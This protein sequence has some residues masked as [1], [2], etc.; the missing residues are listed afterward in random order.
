MRLRAQGRLPF[1]G[2][3]DFELQAEALDIRWIAHLLQLDEALEGVVDLEFSVV[4]TDAE[5]VMDL[6]LSADGFR[7]RD[8]VMERLGANVAYAARRATGDVVLWNDS[9]QVL[10]LDGELPLD[11]SFNAVEDRFPEEVIDLVVVS[12]RFPLSLLMAPFPDYEDVVGTISG[13]VDIGGTSR[14]LAPQGRMSVEGGGVFLGGLGVRYEDVSGTLG[15]FPDGRVEVDMSAQALGTASVEGT[16]MLTTVLDPGLA[17]DFRFDDFQA[18]DRRD[19]TGRLSGAVRLEGSLSRPVV[20]G[21]LFVDEGTLFWEEFQRLAGVSDLLF[22]RSIGLED[23]SVADTTAAVSRSFIGGQ[24]LF[25]QNIRMENTTLTVRRNTWIRGEEMNVQLSG[26]VDL[27]YDRQSQDLALVGTLEAVRGS[28][29][30]GRRALRKQVQVDGGTLRFLGT[31]GINPD[32]DITGRE[33]IRTP[34]G[35]RLTIIASVTGTLLAP[36]VELSSD[37]VGFSEEELLSYLWFGR[38]TYALTS[39][40]NEAVGAGMAIGLNTLSSELGAVMAQGLDFLD[41]L[42]I[43]QQDLG[44]LGSLTANNVQALGTTVVETGFYVA[45]DMFLTLLFRSAAA[46]GGIESW[47]GIRFEW[48]AARGYTLQSYFEDQFFRGRAVGFGELGVQTRKGLGL[49]LF[50]NWSY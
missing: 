22:E 10:S 23:L 15:W 44:S 40:Q 12:D 41:Y 35:D 37:E 18:M 36:R 20:S 2:E 48:T 24:S 30:L 14:I 49:S 6:A 47:P 27:L 29:G 21:D 11:L 38:P 17:L 28:F 16:V 25:L 33:L 19:A 9:L 46:Q 8:Y 4:G 31:P 13:R 50:R 34:E 39:D 43:K 32:L 3:A 26:E 1:D 5:P 45:D 7:F 42:S